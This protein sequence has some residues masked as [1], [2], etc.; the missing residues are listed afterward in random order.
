MSNGMSKQDSDA[1]HGD[2]EAD[3]DFDYDD[4]DIQDNSSPKSRQND[5]SD[6]L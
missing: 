5:D 3:D 4:I 1:I 2:V 6:F